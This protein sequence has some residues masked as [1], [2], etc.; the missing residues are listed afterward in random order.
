QYS[1]PVDRVK[2]FFKSRDDLLPLM[3]EVL[4][5]KILNFLK[6][7]AQFQKPKKKQDKEPADEAS[8]EAEVSSGEKEE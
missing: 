7:E 8:Q 3:N 4:N 6:E 2:E 1:M 5:E